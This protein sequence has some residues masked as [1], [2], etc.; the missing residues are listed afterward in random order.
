[1]RVDRCPFG[2]P[3]S[4]VTIYRPSEN[5]SQKTISTSE[6]L[7]N[8]RDVTTSVSDYERPSHPDLA[9]L[10]K[11]RKI[12]VGQRR[13]YTDRPVT[14]PSITSVKVIEV[15]TEPP[16]QKAVSDV[17]SMIVADVKEEPAQTTPRCPVCANNWER[18]GNRRVPDEFGLC[19]TFLHLARGFGMCNCQT[20]SITPLG[21]ISGGS[22]AVS[23]SE[24]DLS[25]ERKNQKQQRAEKK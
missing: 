20:P 25:V 17:E 12:G 13:Q 23:T 4:N 16:R 9:N 7:P 24:T 21:R 10:H 2:A 11:F 1:M 8:V 22:N 18:Y 15:Q 5:Y 6:P 19:P 14:A 3:Y